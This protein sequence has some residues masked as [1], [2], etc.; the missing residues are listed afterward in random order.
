MA[1]SPPKIGELST[2]DP[3]AP[4]NENLSGDELALHTAVSLR[5]PALHDLWPD[6]V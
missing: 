1:C 2:E 5:S 6:K 4:V 3:G